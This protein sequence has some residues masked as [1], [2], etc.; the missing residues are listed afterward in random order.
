MQYL[1]KLFFIFPDM[2]SRE[3]FSFEKLS[4]QNFQ[5]LY[6]MFEND[7]SPF[8]DERFKHY[9]GAEKYAHELEEF[10]VY[11]PKHGWQ[12]WLFLLENNYAGILHLYD[13]SLE[14]FAENN[15]RCWIGFATKPQLRNQGI[16]KKAVK[17]F[18]QYVFENYKS[19]KYIHSMIMKEN[20]PAQMLLKS[21]GFAR[22]FTERISKEHNFYVFTRSKC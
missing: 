20:L 21:L 16:T 22:D 7:G 17:Y 1:K 18:M 2:E 6:L 3:N 4:S 13:L 12:D 11:S 8:T 5:Q 15:K 9:D 10:G 14:T 19:I